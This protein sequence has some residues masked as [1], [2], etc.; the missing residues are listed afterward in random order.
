MIC[1]GK[2]FHVHTAEDRKDRPPRVG[3]RTAGTTRR[4]VEAER[5]LDRPEREETG[6]S[7]VERYRGALPW[8]HLCTRTQTLVDPCLYGEPLEFF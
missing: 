5:S 4:E 6:V 3:R 8:R 1:E 7:S 2:L